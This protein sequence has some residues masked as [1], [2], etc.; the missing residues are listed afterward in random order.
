MA[1]P[2]SYREEY[3]KQAYNLALLGAIDRDLAKAF[4]VSEQTINAWKQ[5]QP[6]FLESLRDGKA[7]ADAEVA[8]S[9]FQRATGYRHDSEEIKVINGEVV[10]V[11]IQKQYPPDTAA[12]IFWLKN[13]TKNNEDPW[14]DTIEHAGDA[15]HPV[16]LIQGAALPKRAADTE[17]TNSV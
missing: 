9:L 12:A 15:E 2:S 4:D 5:A 10:R 3:A 7:Q 14:K 17:A 13:R 8:K 11:K 16:V 1:R 6:E